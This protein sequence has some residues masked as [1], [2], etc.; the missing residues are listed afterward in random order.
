V[1]LFV[2]WYCHKRGREVRLE[3]EAAAAGQPPVEAGSRIEELPD[4]AALPPPPVGEAARARMAS[5]QPAQPNTLPAPTQQNVPW[6]D[7]G[8]AKVPVKASR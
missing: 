3:K 2:L 8:K 4:D 5:S 1:L 6:A 7:K